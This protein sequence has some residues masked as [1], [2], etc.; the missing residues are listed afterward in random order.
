MSDEAAIRRSLKIKTGIV[1]RLT[2]ESN[3]YRKE[4]GD[5]RAK[6]E[7]SKALGEDSWEA[8]NARNLVN[9]TIKTLGLTNGK[10]K[11]ETAKL[12]DLLE[13]V[14]NDERIKGDESL[15]EAKLAV[16]AAEVSLEAEAKDE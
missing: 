14:E 3:V 8:K 2:K 7:Q 15:D 6:A 1:K 13:T 4:I 10:L 5:L 11:D 12:R 16:E 9:E